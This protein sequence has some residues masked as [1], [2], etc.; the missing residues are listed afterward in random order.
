VAPSPNICLEE[1][2]QPVGCFQIMIFFLI[3][4]FPAAKANPA[5]C[6]AVYTVFNTLGHIDQRQSQ[7]LLS[8]LSLYRLSLQHGILLVPNDKKYG[9]IHLGGFTWSPHDIEIYKETGERTIE[10]IQR[11]HVNRTSLLGIFFLSLL[12][13]FFL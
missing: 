6:A 3:V 9:N 8:R 13:I 12:G 5:S 11:Y 2:T 10:L 1:L 7:K 4:L